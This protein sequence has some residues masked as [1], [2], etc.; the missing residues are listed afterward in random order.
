MREP[1]YV[2]DADVSDGRIGGGLTTRAPSVLTVNEAAV[3]GT[4]VA[5]LLAIRVAELLNADE[6]R[7]ADARKA[8]AER[9][10]TRTVVTAPDRSTEAGRTA[11]LLDGRYGTATT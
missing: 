2:E 10:E 3:G 4:G 9:R 11:A 8:K 6:A 5:H 1:Y 7:K